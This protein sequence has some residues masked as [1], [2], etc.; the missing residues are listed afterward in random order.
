MIQVSLLLG[1]RLYILLLHALGVSL[2][3]SR[4]FYPLYAAP[5][6]SSEGGEAAAAARHRFNLVVVQGNRDAAAEQNR[7]VPRETF[8]ER[9][10]D[11]NKSI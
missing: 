8:A 9:E 11:F 2:L 4:R 7:N 5:P 1:V 10:I 6:P 3:P